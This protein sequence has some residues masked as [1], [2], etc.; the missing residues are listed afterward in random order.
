MSDALPREH[1]AF[2]HSLSDR[3][4]IRFCSSRVDERAIIILAA[5]APEAALGIDGRG[6]P[7][8]N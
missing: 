8:R 1:I 5:K 6:P 7:F 3:G 4:H 2:L